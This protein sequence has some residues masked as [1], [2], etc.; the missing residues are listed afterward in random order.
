MLAPLAA[1]LS[2]EVDAKIPDS[3]RG[4][5]LG[6]YSGERPT[7]GYS[8]NVAGARI[9]GGRVALRLP[10]RGPPRPTRS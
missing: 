5:Y 7:G 10:L 1:D 2:G 3:G 6:A 8:V 9:E 4:T